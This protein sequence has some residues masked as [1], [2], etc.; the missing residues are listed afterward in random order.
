VSEKAEIAIIGG[1]GF[2]RLAPSLDLN[3]CVVEDVETPYSNIPVKLSFEELEDVPV[4]FLARHGEQHRFPPHKVN[5][6]AN[7]W[8]L[9][10]FGIKHI[11]AVNTLGAIN[12]DFSL[13]QLIIPDQLIDYTWGRDHTFFDGLNSLSDH[14]DFTEPFTAELREKLLTQAEKLKLSA[15]TSACVACTQGPRLETA[16][17][18]RK[19]AKDGCDAVGMT[20][21]PEA[22]L[23]RELK[24]SYAS[25]GLVVN[26]AAGLAEG[27]ISIEAIQEVLAA[28]LTDVRKLISAVLPTI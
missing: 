24:I 21:M 2:Y 11:I 25:I 16:A 19:L 13:P 14:I 15:A 10:E 26:M 8:A 17:E 27:E 28:G 20:L 23:A 7:L 22:A 4:C 9:H 6:R 12:T 18:I 3:R 1:S 5:Y